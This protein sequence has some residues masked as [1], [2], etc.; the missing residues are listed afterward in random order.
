MTRAYSQAHKFGVETAIPAQVIGLEP[1]DDL[2]EALVLVS[3][4]S[5]LGVLLAYAGLKGVV[6]WLPVDLP[7]VGDIYMGWRALI[8]TAGLA[9]FLEDALSDAVTA[10]E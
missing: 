6:V 4:G 2:S 5:A 3:I 9:C 7:R 8:F 1:A 10:G